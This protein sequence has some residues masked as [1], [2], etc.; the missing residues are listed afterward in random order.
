VLAAQEH[1]RGIRFEA[2]LAGR[3]KNGAVEQMLSPDTLTAQHS[4]S[5]GGLLSALLLS[6]MLPA[7]Q[8]H[9]WSPP[10]VALMSPHVAAMGC[11]Q[12]AMYKSGRDCHGRLVA[13]KGDARNTASSD[14]SVNAAI[15]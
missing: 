11:K 4:A 5:D 12:A 7:G 8:A 15:S 2:L 9:G 1:E 6:T 10:W 14:T 13:A 3:Q